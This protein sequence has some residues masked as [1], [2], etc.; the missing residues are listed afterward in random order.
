MAVG[1]SVLLKAVLNMAWTLVQCLWIGRP[2]WW[3]LFLGRGTG[4]CAPT[5]GGSHT[6]DF[7]SIVESQIQKEQCRFCPVHGTLDQLYN[8]FNKGLCTKKRSNV[9]QKIIPRRKISKL[10][11]TLKGGRQGAEVKVGKALNY[12][13]MEICG[14]HEVV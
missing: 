2:R 3:C 1:L 6:S 5:S 14:E 7:D 4:G 9:E 11:Q 12:C 13:N 8:N 10:T